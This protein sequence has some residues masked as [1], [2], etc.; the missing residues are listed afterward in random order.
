MGGGVVGVVEVSGAWVDG[1][2][3]SDAE[4]DFLGFLDGVGG[5]WVGLGG[6]GGGGN[7]VGLGHGDALA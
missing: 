5:C 6:D 3:D 7:A 2:T 4:F 1:D